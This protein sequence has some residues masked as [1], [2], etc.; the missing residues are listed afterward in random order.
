MPRLDYENITGPV[1]DFLRAP[2]NAGRYGTDPATNVP[3]TIANPS[4]ATGTQAWNDRVTSAYNFGRTWP[5]AAPV[6]QPAV[7]A[8]RASPLGGLN[9]FSDQ[10]QGL[11]PGLDAAANFG[12]RAG[13]AAAPP[14]AHNFMR[15]FAQG[16][17]G[18]GGARGKPGPGGGGWISGPT[19]TTP[20][21]GGSSVTTD[22][23]YQAP[24][25]ATWERH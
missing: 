20:T 18:H 15:G 6:L 25:G 17:H 13:V 12:S 23:S 9:P 16:L 14:S 5:N 8:L 22:E 10:V 11:P 24:P 4:D 21:G 1:R 3:G 2:S 7:N 19:F